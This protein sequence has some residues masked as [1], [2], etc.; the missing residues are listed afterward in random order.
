MQLTNI[1]SGELI[2]DKQLSMIIALLNKL[3]N[4][5]FKIDAYDINIHELFK[6]SR[7]NGLITIIYPSV[8]N[9]IGKNRN[10]N[11]EEWSNYYF[12]NN[13][14]NIIVAQQISVIYELLKKK[15]LHPLIIKGLALSRYYKNPYDRTMGDLDL[16]IHQSEWDKAVDV[17]CQNGY[18][19]IDDN[20]SP[21][22]VEF[23]KN[24]SIMIELHKQLLHTGYLGGRD[25]REWYDHI[26]ENKQLNNIDKNI[27]FF[28]MCEEDE[29][30]NQ[31]VHFATHFIYF[32]TK[33]T[34]IFE[35]ALIINSSRKEFEW[36]YIYKILENL[37]IISF[38]KLLFS[39]CK[40]YFNSQVPD[41]L[42][43]DNIKIQKQFIED[44]YKYFCA[45]RNDSKG[46]INILSNYRFL[47]RYKVLQPIAWLI[48]FK[49]QL[50]NN[51]FKT[52]A[53]KNAYKNIKMINK[54]LNII[55]NYGLNFVKGI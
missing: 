27:E 39:I 25:T 16:L 46:W 48:E 9:C 29:L 1:S 52:Y 26:W 35:M 38:A 13:Y 14:N 17:L 50:Q 28:S 18:K 2:V 7:L 37:R 22:H 30:I 47:F 49:T 55:R 6:A 43:I 24:N 33:I 51:G 41:Y 31:I 11:I 21:L 20:N 23:I 4:N 32:G 19:Q 45:T 34:Q 5:E 40:K 54:K 42:C 15:N 36:D 53:I 8:Y 12:K 44:L 10:V 3:M